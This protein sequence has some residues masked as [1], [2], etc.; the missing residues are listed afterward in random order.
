MGVG[1]VDVPAMLV[2][3]EVLAIQND[4]RESGAGFGPC[5]TRI[6]IGMAA[7]GAMVTR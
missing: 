5:S 4:G 2:I 6:G 3:A 1:P 7:R